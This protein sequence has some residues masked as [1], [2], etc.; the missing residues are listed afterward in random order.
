MQHLNY[1]IL[2]ITF[3]LIIWQVIMLRKPFPVTKASVIKSMVST[4]LIMVIYAFILRASILSPAAW[5]LLAAG[6]VIGI[7]YGIATKV[8]LQDLS[9][10]A[11]R[12][13][14]YIIFWGIVYI[15]THFLSQQLG[16]G[17]VTLGLTMMMFSFGILLMQYGIL[18][19]KAIA[20]KGKRV[21]N[22][23]QK[24]VGSDA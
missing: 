16:S 23:M 1:A 9:I 4:P 19:I 18:S 14:F 3:V 6:L 8:Y 10:M 12:S 7:I 2:G 5:Y 15:L 11:K 22:Q 24:G 20:V 21:E 17:G 13:S